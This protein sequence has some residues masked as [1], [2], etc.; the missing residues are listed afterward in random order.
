MKALALLALLLLSPLALANQN[1]SAG[2]AS[3]VTMTSDNGDGCGG[4]NGSHVRDARV[5]VPI[6]SRNSLVVDASQSCY[7]STDTTYGYESHGNNTGVSV[8]RMGPG[9]S[10]GPSAGAGWGTFHYSDRYGGELDQCYSGVYA[11]GTGVSP[12]CPTLDGSGAPM[13]PYLP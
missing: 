6:D 3:V 8:A 5:V 12:G 11:L 7:D 10:S 4:A 2:P 1:L 13:L 9:Q